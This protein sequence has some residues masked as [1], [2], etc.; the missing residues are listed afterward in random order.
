MVVVVVPDFFH[1]DNLGHDS[2]T[3][4]V[5]ADHGE[6]GVGSAVL[7]GHPGN[8]AGI[9]VGVHV[10]DGIQR[11]VP[12]DIQ[13]GGSTAVL[14][15]MRVRALCVPGALVPVV[16]RRDHVQIGRAGF[17]AHQLEFAAVRP[18]AQI[19]RD[20]G[21][22]HAVRYVPDAV[23]K[24]PHTGPGRIVGKIVPA[25]KI[26][27]DAFVDHASRGIA[28]LEPGLRGVID[29]RCAAFCDKL[30]QVDG[31]KPAAPLAADLDLLFIAFRADSDGL[32][33]PV[34][35]PVLFGFHLVVILL[36]GG[37]MLLAAAFGDQVVFQAVVHHHVAGDRILRGGNPQPVCIGLP[38]VDVHLRLSGQSLRPDAVQVVLDVFDI[39]R[40]RHLVDRQVHIRLGIHEPR[41]VGVRIQIGQGFHDIR[42]LPVGRIVVVPAD[43]GVRLADTSGK[44]AQLLVVS[45]FKGDVVHQL[46][47]QAVDI[48]PGVGGVKAE[49]RPVADN[50][51]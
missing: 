27:E 29:D 13:I 42:G 12:V 4:I 48:R 8:Q 33:V 14:V 6:E 39:L 23:G 21:H 36:L 44:C 31:R 17:L 49:C 19:Q 15:D 18:F 24:G 40:L 38:F 2:D 37:V 28:E 46:A 34:S 5:V 25:F 1:A 47:A 16:I 45:A 30:V 41:V 35:V 10:V 32:A 50:A 26:E 51:V 22:I 20:R 7:I 3:G 11:G 43:H 9:V